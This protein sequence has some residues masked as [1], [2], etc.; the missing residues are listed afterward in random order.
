M[1]LQPVDIGPG[2]FKTVLGSVGPAQRDH[3]STAPGRDR[4]L[5]RSRRDAFR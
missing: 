4:S 5:P 3:A 2:G 1:A